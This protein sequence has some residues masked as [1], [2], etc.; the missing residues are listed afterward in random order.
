MIINAIIDRIE[1]GTAFLL[2]T[3]TGIEVSIPADIISGRCNEGDLISLTFDKN[4]NAVI[5][6]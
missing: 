6:E 1:N 2:S 5:N 4:N 3:E